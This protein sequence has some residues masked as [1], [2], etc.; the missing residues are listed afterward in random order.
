MKGQKKGQRWKML[1]SQVSLLDI[2]VA[3]V[4]PSGDDPLKTFLAGGSWVV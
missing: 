4:T 1:L 3:T 2:S